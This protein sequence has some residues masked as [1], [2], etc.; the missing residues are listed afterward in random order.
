MANENAPTGGRLRFDKSAASIA[1]NSRWIAGGVNSHFRTG[2][3][4][5]PLVFERGEGPYLFDVDGNRLIDYYAGMGA[6][7]LGHSPET[8]RQAVKAQVDRGILFAGQTAIEA[9]AARLLCERIPSAERVRFGSSGSEVA[10]A[11][12]RLMRAATGRRT[13]IKFEGHYHGWF[14]NI[15]WSTAPSLNAAGP[16]DAPIPV[17]GSIG[18]HP[19]ESDGLEIMGWNDLARLETRLAQG[20]IAGVIMEPA[21][22]NQGAIAPGAGY[23]EGALAACRRHG[24]ILCF[25][26][27]ITGFRLAR[28]GAQELFGVTPDLSIFAKAIANGFPVAAIVGRAGLIDMFATAGVLHGGTFNSQPVAMAAMVATQNAL[29]PEHFAKTGERG[30]RLQTGIREALA[31]AGIKAQITGFPLVF[32]VAFGLDRPARNYRDI[33]AADKATYVK[34][35]VALL[36]RGVRVLERG[37]WFVSSAHDDAVIDA[38]LDAVRDAAQE[39]APR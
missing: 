17:A 26:E 32:H 37:A 18:Q 10:Q 5:G 21:M 16:E 34:F 23:L 29:T 38:T 1:E 19:A 33:A 4:P 9:E 36:Q 27:V 7:V 35:A 13:V 2:M 39:I 24:T 31:A 22:C 3:S 15:L 8:V 11:A 20:D 6:T 12:M 30:L 25:D 28:G 14:D